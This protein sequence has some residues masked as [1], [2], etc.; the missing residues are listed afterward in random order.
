MND[1]QRQRYNRHRGLLTDTDESRERRNDRLKQHRTQTKLSTIM[2]A[3]GLLINPLEFQVIENNN[4]NNNNNNGQDRLIGDD[5]NNATRVSGGVLSVLENDDGQKR[6]LLIQNTINWIK[7]E[8]NAGNTKGAI[9]RLRYLLSFPFDSVLHLNINTNN[10]QWFEGLVIKMVCQDEHILLFM[11]QCIANHSACDESITLEACWCITNLAASSNEMVVSKMLSASPYLIQYLTCRNALLQEQSMWALGNLAKESTNNRDILCSQGIIPPLLHIFNNLNSKN[12]QF[13]VT[14]CFTIHAILFPGKLNNSTLTDR[15]KQID[16]VVLETLLKN[17]LIDGIQ[18][19][20]VSSS[21]DNEAKRELLWLVCDLASLPMVHVFFDS[22]YIKLIEGINIIYNVLNTAAA[23]ADTFDESEYGLIFLYYIRTLGHL[24]SNEKLAFHLLNTMEHI[25]SLSKSPQIIKETIYLLSNITSLDYKTIGPLAQHEQQPSSFSR[26]FI[27][28]GCVPILFQS[29]FRHPPSIQCQLLYLYNNLYCEQSFDSIFVDWFGSIPDTF[30]EVMFVHIEGAI[31]FR[32]GFLQSFA[33]AGVIW[34]SNKHLYSDSD[35]Q[36]FSTSEAA[37]KACENTY[38]S[39]DGIIEWGYLATITSQA[40]MTFVLSNIVSGTSAWISGSDDKEQGIWR[41]NTG[42]EIGEYYYDV[43]NEKCYTYC[44]MND[45]AFSFADGNGLVVST[46][47]LITNKGSGTL[48]KVV[49]EFGGLESKNVPRLTPISQPT[50]GGYVL[51]EAL[52]NGFNTT[53]AT[54]TIAPAGDTIYYSPSVRTYPTLVEAYVK[55]GNGGP[56]TIA[57]T[58]GA[59]TI[60]LPSAFQPPHLRAVYPVFTAGQLVTLV[61]NNFGMTASWLTVTIGTA[62]T[63]CNSIVILEAHNMFTCT[64]TAT[65]GTNKFL[66]VTITLGGHTK[67]FF[68]PALYYPSSGYFVK[69][70]SVPMI[71]DIAFFRTTDRFQLYGQIGRVTSV[72]STALRTFL[73]NTLAST[74]TWKLWQNYFATDNTLVTLVGTSVGAFA[75]DVGYYSSNVPDATADGC[76]RFLFTLSTSVTSIAN[77]ADEGY[78]LL[79]FNNNPTFIKSDRLDSFETSY[80][81][82]TS[83]CSIAFPMTNYGLWNSEIVFT[84]MGVNI[85]DFKQN[86]DRF[87]VTL[88]PGY[89]NTRLRAIIDN[90]NPFNSLPISYDPPTIDT[91]VIDSGYATITGNNFYSSSSLVSVTVG[92]AA[93]TSPSFLTPH[94]VIQCV[95]P[96][97]PTLSTYVTI[98][99]TQSNSVTPTLAAPKVTSVSSAVSIFGGLITINGFN[100]YSTASAVSVTVGGIAC[101]SVSIVVANT[102]IS[103]IAPASSGSKAVVVTVSTRVSNSDV[104]AVYQPPTISSV[105]QTASNTI[106]IAGS[107]FGT[108]ASVLSITLGASTISNTLCTA[109]S[110]SVICSSLPTTL[111]NGLISIS[112][113]NQIAFKFTPTVTTNTLSTTPQST[114]TINGNHFDSLTPTFGGSSITCTG[115]YTQ[116]VCT[117]LPNSVSGTL[118]LSPSVSTLVTFDPFVQSMNPST[119]PTSGSTVIVQGGHF[120]N[121]SGYTLSVLLGGS[122]PLTFTKLDLDL[123]SVVIPAGYGN[124]KYINVQVNSKIS[125]PNFS[126]GYAT[127]SISTV[128]VEEGYVTI[129]GS[130]FFTSS[131][132]VSVTVGA[133]ACTSPTI[134]TAHTVIRCVAPANPSLSTYV[135]VSGTQSNSVTPTLAAPKVTSATLV[136]FFGGLVTISGTNFYGTSSSVSVTVGGIAC[137]SVSIVTVNTQISC[138]VPASSGSKAIIV[139]AFGLTSNSDSSVVYQPPTISSVTQTA[140]NTISIAGSGFGTTASALSITLGALTIS[141]TLCTAASTSV[142][143]SNLPT[144]LVNGLVSISGSNQIAFKFTP[145]ITTSTLSVTPQ[146]TITINGNHFDGLVPTFGVPI[147]CTGTYTQLV[148]TFTAS[149]VSGPLYVTPTQSINV[150]FSPYVTSITPAGPVTTSGSTVTIQGGHFENHSGYTLSVLVGGSALSSFTKL[151]IGT[152]VVQIPA[153][154]GTSK[155]INVQVNSIV[156]PNFS[157]NYASPTIISVVVDQGFSTITGTNFY[158]DSAIIAVTVGAA[159]CTS[160]TFLTAHTTILCVAPTDPTLSTN[161]KVSGT[162]SNSVTPT[163]AAPKVTSVSSTVSIFG[164]LITINGFNFYSTASA[165]SV[166]V[167]GIACSSVSIVVANTQISCV[168]PA[169]S[170]SKAVVVTVSTRVSNSDVLAVY[171]PPTISSVTQTAANTISIAGSGFGTTASALSITLGASTISN[172]LCTAASTSV[173]CSSL[174]TTLING[175]VSISGSNQIAFKFTPIITTSTLSTTPQSTITINGNHFDSLTPTFGGSSITCTGTYTQ[176]VCTFLPNSVSGTL[177]LSPSVST[178]VTFDPFVQSINPS[179]TIPTSGSTVIVQGGHFENHSGYTLSVLLGGS[180]PLTFT[181]LDLDSLSVQ[182]P[183]GTGTNFYFVVQVNA[184]ISSQVVF[185]Y[186]LPSI[187]YTKTSGNQLTI[188]GSNFGSQL[189]ISLDIGSSTASVS[190]VNHN[191]IVTTIPNNA[192]QTDQILLT[193]GGQSTTY[194]SGITLHPS[195][196][197]VSSVRTSGGVITITAAYAPVSAIPQ[198]YLLGSTNTPAVAITSTHPYK[199]T[200]TAPAGC[201]DRL[202]SLSLGSSPIS[203]VGTINYLQPSITS[204]SNPPFQSIAPITITGVNLPASG[205]S[206]IYV[207]DIRY[208]CTN[209]QYVGDTTITCSFDGLNLHPPYQTISPVYGDPPMT[210]YMVGACSTIS[211]NVFKYQPIAI[212]TVIP[213]YNS[214]EIKGTGFIF[215]VTGPVVMIDSPTSTPLTGC[216]Y[217]T[218]TVTCDMTYQLYPPYVIY[219]EGGPYRAIYEN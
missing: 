40:E 47:G 150:V 35:G 203:S 125:A 84:A 176:L 163:L 1:V 133:A 82:P 122:T 10:D 195:I 112:G 105:T 193:V 159:A 180:T 49:C 67:K 166:K 123:L 190:T 114:I 215:K 99:G 182:I 75:S 91:V 8:H 53:P 107:G 17:N 59:T 77:Q 6:T 209:I 92:A 186:S 18:K 72:T 185:S 29:Y 108:T 120:E 22:I 179:G 13:I 63:A 110:T 34:S 164:G 85:T 216:S 129:T 76:K 45:A 52:S 156:S 111:I 177:N 162:Q 168:A 51:I 9:E 139:T 126:F 130:N 14:C 140:A 169:S 106:S 145:T 173:I 189:S 7:F 50:Q 69:A 103:C 66:P 134:L 138:T 148:C 197:S 181:K 55:P 218:T 94:T 151:D 33:W 142:I 207:S 188:V 83:G 213:M 187:S 155:I 121:H 158:S 161:V 152:L 54:V 86:G 117:F 11:F 48:Y 154:Y 39:H 196:I 157:F 116:L 135:T 36:T 102:Q 192:Q 21:I 74:I 32:K 172:T 115:T 65:L 88:P 119:V 37:R 202:V 131:S 80:N 46:A 128:F 98:A 95:I 160:P 204:V 199:F 174:P 217:T 43:F 137:T 144:T 109:A 165:V 19:H 56:M 25:L 208:M 58:S 15:I 143:C 124:S 178:L 5:T 136:P 41:Y 3:R 104:L 90:R 62:N 97:D 30:S 78:L 71:P 141:N 42:P 20:L 175:L 24:Y 132:L 205:I 113:S 27:N 214:I 167:G 4:N 61:G 73:Q 200:L 211:A 147:S 219:L 212:T 170:G 210:I 87:F 201:A 101:S 79:A 118:N 127:P 60:S 96:A 68:H 171:Q 81:C 191:T 183:P 44:P 70:F 16:V 31:A 153:G 64:L 206:F 184:K 146:S 23:A 198:F 57:I 28:N 12:S 89:G 100:F 26:I 93:C 194:S 149:A 38:Y 2:S